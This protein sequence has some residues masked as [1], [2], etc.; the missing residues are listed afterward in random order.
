M[1]YN[2][3]ANINQRKTV[4][5]LTLTSI[6]DNYMISSVNIYPGNSSPNIKGDIIEKF[7]KKMLDFLSFEIM[8]NYAIRLFFDFENYKRNMGEDIIDIFPIEYLIK[9]NIKDI[10][11][12]KKYYTMT[13]VADE[14]IRVSSGRTFGINLKKAKCPDNEEFIILEHGFYFCSFNIVHKSEE[15]WK[16]KE[17]EFIK[18]HMRPF[19]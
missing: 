8:Y 13:L 4:G 18:R 12:E 11:S 14:I 2:E 6:K 10:E 3:V 19:K 9:I 16:K 5:G 15:E 1:E 17:I 7:R